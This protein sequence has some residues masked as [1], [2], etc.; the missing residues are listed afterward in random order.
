MTSMG[1]WVTIAAGVVGA[2]I[3]L[4]GQQWGRRGENRTHVGELVLEQCAHLIALSE[5]FRYRAWEE[6]VLG[7]EGRVASWDLSSHRL[8]KA[9]AEIL[10]RDAAFLVSADVQLGDGGVVDGEDGGAG[11]GPA[12]CFPAGPRCAWWRLGGQ[13][14]VTSAAAVRALDSS[15][16]A[17]RPA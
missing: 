13:S 14:D 9:R 16:M 2:A 7:Q 11:K 3:A 8:A 15:T 5:D 10:C 1:A 4:V 17:L 12:G 6:S